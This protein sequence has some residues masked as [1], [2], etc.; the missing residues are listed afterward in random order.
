MR[1]RAFIAGLGSAAAWPVVARAQQKVFRI[2]MLFAGGDYRTW[3]GWGDF[4]EA[5][6]GLGWIEGK[7][8]VF[9]HRFANDQLDRLP[10]LAAELV[11]LNVD[12]I[13]TGGTLAPIAAKR[14][15]AKIPIVMQNAG[16]PLGSG[17][18]TNL[19]RPGENV[20]GLS[21][22]AP[23]LGGKRL[24]LL[25]VSS[26]NLTTKIVREAAILAAEIVGQDGRGKDGLV[27]RGPGCGTS[28]LAA[29][30]PTGRSQ[31]RSMGPAGIFY[32]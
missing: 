20:T 18:V 27:G 9:E 6:R 22:M 31:I 23:D 32:L 21:L 8:F 13:V 3:P 28:S 16:D 2:G 1:R 14:A 29:L 19:A 4:I 10:E 25:K 11:R 12:V 7:N 5:L 30:L 24:E 15:T 17:L 26:P